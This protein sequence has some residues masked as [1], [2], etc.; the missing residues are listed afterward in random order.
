MAIAITGSSKNSNAST[1]SATVTHG[2]TIN[3]ND[4][5]LAF[6]SCNYVVTASD[7]NGAYTFTKDFEAG[8]L[9]SAT[10]SVFSRVAGSSEPSSY[11]FDIGGNNRWSLILLVVSG[12]DTASIWDVAP[13]LSNYNETGGGTT[14]S[15][16]SINTLTDGALAL[17]LGGVDGGSA[18][19]FSAPTNG[20]SIVDQASPNQSSVVLSKPMPT[21]GA[22]GATST[23]VSVSESHNS[24]MM[25]LAE[26]AASA[27]LTV[28]EASISPGGSV[29][30]TTALVGIQRAWITDSLGNTF[31]LTNVTDTGGDLPALA[32]GLSACLFENDVTVTV[33][34]EAA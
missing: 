28:N 17:I 26:G 27:T 7:D 11:S 20:F 29:T 22:V 15:T 24:F 34:P 31:A 21:A 14:M 3:E 23:T 25:A 8:W 16:T 13:L 4:V 6:I 19:T 10:F 32:H 2:L 18:T 30:W 9:S 5:V 12:V 1:A 33:S